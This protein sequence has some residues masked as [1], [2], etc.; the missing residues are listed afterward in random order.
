[1]PVEVALAAPQRAHDAGSPRRR[2]GR[3]CELDA[4]EV[5]LVRVPAHADAEREAAAESSCSVATSFA[6]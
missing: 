2:A 4:H 1:V 3:A 5:E 6:R